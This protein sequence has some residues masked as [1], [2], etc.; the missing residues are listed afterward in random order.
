MVPVPLQLQ[1]PD[2]LHGNQVEAGAHSSALPRSETLCLLFK[3]C[4]LPNSLCV[5]AFFLQVAQCKTLMEKS[6]CISLNLKLS[7][8]GVRG[9]QIWFPGRVQ[10]WFIY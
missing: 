3:H 8:S 1:L 10:L 4:L 2:N 6:T 7:A 5:T 9:E